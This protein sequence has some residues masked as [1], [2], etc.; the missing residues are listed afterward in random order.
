MENLYYSI[1][2]FNNNNHVARSNNHYGIALAIMP[3][4]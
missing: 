3:A 1:L 2:F 4:A